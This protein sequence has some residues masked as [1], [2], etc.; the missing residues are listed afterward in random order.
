MKTKFASEL[1]ELAEKAQKFI[2]K[3]TTKEKI[4]LIP[5]DEN[6][7]VKREQ[8]FYELPIGIQIGKHGYYDEYAI[9]ALSKD[10]FGEVVAHGIAKT[11]ADQEEKDFPLGDLYEWPVCALADMLSE[12]LT[13]KN[14]SNGKK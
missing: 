7:E 11:E 12:K 6:G 1:Q 9:A 10:Q 13:T 2:K 5:V 8:E 14:K 4:F 3:N